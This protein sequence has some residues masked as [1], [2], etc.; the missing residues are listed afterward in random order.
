LSDKR[1]GRRPS[2]QT[3]VSYLALFLVLVGGTA[4]AAA[5]INSGDVINGSLKSVDLKCNAGVKGADVPRNNLRPAD[6]GSG[7]RASIR[8]SDVADNTLGGAA[9]DEGSVAASRVVG[10]LGGIVGQPIP[11][12]GPA[13]IPFNNAAYTQSANEFNELI[14]GGQVTF[15]PACTTPR[16]ATIYLLLDSPLLAI[17]SL[18]ASANV[19]DNTG[20][21]VSKRI[22]FVPF[23]GGGVGQVLPPP[24]AATPR[25][26][27]VQAD[28]SCNAGSGVTLDSAT[29]DVVGHR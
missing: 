15:P 14:A 5:T 11:N 18:V 28:A 13:L 22:Y 25:Q 21:S 4:Y 29:V 12:A 20:G 7:A 10:R 24:A 27:F 2:H 3:V 8:G 19:T 6:F 9:V 26:F 17:E 23:F 1:V 16:S